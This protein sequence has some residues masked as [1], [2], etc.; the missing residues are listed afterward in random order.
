M[1]S[2]S[3]F[4]LSNPALTR[5]QSFHLEVESATQHSMGNTTGAE[6]R[7]M[8]LRELEGL[9]LEKSFPEPEAKFMIYT[10]V[11]IL[12]QLDD[13]IRGVINRTYWEPPSIPLISSER[14]TWNSH[15]LIPWTGDKPIWVEL[16]INNIDINGHPFHLVSTGI[17]VP[18]I[19]HSFRRSSSLFH[20]KYTANLL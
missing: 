1:K 14:D 11:Q 15:Q 20:S 16:T 8:N 6:L 12:N 3:S 9:P 4:I 7:Q 10:T 13:D 19:C 5:I 18:K 2:A 17:L